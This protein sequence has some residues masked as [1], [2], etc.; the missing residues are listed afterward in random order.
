MGRMDVLAEDVKGIGFVCT[1]ASF[2]QSQRLE[3]AFGNNLNNTHLCLSDRVQAPARRGYHLP[4]S[5]LD[6]RHH[7][8]GRFDLVR[9]VRS[10][11]GRTPIARSDL[12]VSPTRKWSRRGH[13]WRAG[14]RL[15]VRRARSALNWYL[16]LSLKENIHP[17]GTWS[18]LQGYAYFW[19][20]KGPRANWLGGRLPWMRL[21]SE[22]V[23]PAGYPKQHH[24]HR[25]GRLRG[26]QTQRTND[27]MSYVEPNT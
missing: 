2:Y 22:A 4:R 3:F 11:V 27:A 14:A 24:P 1:T 21:D 6:L 7:F 25:L 23:V 16:K 15:R 12:G 9:A 8:L 18:I 5:L 17:P 26:Q 10:S 20:L 19:S 13:P